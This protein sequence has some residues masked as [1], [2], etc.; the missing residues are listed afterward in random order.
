MDAQI[1][2]KNDGLFREL[3]NQYP[4]KIKKDGVVYPTLF[5]FF[6]MSK[7]PNYPTFQAMLSKSSIENIY[8][9]CNAKDGDYKNKIRKDW[10]MI[11]GKVLQEGLEAKFVG[12]EEHCESL[13]WTNDH[14][15]V[16]GDEYCEE[17]E[18]MALLLKELRNLMFNTSSYS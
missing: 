4:L 18:I 2:F 3:S 17:P 15:L 14:D 11:K 10:G 16:C 1:E 12:N 7:F 6:H 13:E 8:R 5:H 9:L